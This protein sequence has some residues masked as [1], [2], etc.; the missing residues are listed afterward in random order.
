MGFRINRGIFKVLD[1]ATGTYKEKLKIDGLATGEPE[2]VVLENYNSDTYK[3][4]FF[5]YTIYNDTKDSMRSG[6]LQV[7]FNDTVA[8]FNE[9]STM[10]IG[11]TSTCI[12]DVVN[13][14]GS[15]DVRFTAP[16]STFKI[17]YHTR[18]V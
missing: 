2:P 10:D 17:S 5:D 1:T 3:G 11:D 7:A 18:T 9:V 4:V 6:T 15:V 8:V 16:N 14:N 13:S 12:L